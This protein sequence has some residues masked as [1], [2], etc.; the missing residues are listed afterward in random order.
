MIDRTRTVHGI[1]SIFA[2]VVAWRNLGLPRLMF[3]SELAPIYARI[4]ALEQF[5]RDTRL[6]VLDRSRWHADPLGAL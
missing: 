6:L 1:A 4:E 3:S 5:N 2:T